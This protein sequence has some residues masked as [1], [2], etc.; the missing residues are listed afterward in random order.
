M[1][2][3]TGG[4]GLL[5]RAILREI[6]GSI[7]ACRTCEVPMDLRD[8][9]SVR[10]VLDRVRPKVIIH[11]GA[12]SNADYCELNK[13]EATLVNQMATEV[14]AREARRLNYFIVFVSSD[15]VF[16]GKS[17]SYTEEDVPNPVNHYGLTK[18]KAEKAIESETQEYAIVRPATIYGPWDARL[19][20]NFALWILRN[21]AG[22]QTIRL[23]I[24]QI[25]SPTLNLGLARMIHEITR[26]QIH[27]IIHTTDDVSISK[28]EFGIRLAKLFDLD[29]NRII[30]VTMDSM[31]WIARRPK[32]SSLNVGKAKRVLKNGPMTLDKA[33]ELFKRELVLSEST[34]SS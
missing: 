6:P 7:G 2:L 27:G 31:G 14:I 23:V 32:N 16:D 17:W 4:S 13:S 9:E 5:G 33:L 19:K 30:P 1:I 11:A 29:V 10:R 34:I 25:A 28:Y 15:Y 12:F 26:R 22:G 20:E 3:V 24:D 21:L 8:L 18:L